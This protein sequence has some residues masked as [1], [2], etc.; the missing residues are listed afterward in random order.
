MCVSLCHSNLDVLVY[1]CCICVWRLEI[2]LRCC[3][4][5]G[6]I[7]KSSWKEREWCGW[8][9]EGQTKVAGV[10]FSSHST[11]A[12]VKPRLFTTGK[13]AERSP[14]FQFWYLT[15]CLFFFCHLVKW[16]VG[17]SNVCNRALDIE[18][19]FFPRVSHLAGQSFVF[20]WFL[21]CMCVCFACSSVYRYADSCIHI[22]KPEEDVECLLC[23]FL[24]SQDLWTRNLLF[25]LSLMAG[26]LLGSACLYFQC[27]R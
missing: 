4:Y 10:C 3:S 19:C 12:Q 18:I 1:M 15:L 21:A 23:L 20:G 17:N 14:E 16:C 25:W 8:S 6:D 26:G 11:P 13:R 7:H 24:F 9:Q 22:Q 5:S 27:W 2:N